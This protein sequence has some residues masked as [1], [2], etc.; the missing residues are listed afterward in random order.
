MTQQ[1]TQ[2]AGLVLENF[3][4]L[5]IL[6]E[7]KFAKLIERFVMHNISINYALVYLSELEASIS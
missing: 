1:K 7:N 3:G 5:L 6:K 4:G 2:N